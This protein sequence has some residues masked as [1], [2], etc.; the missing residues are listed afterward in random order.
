MPV[1][2]I[3]N[4][5]GDWYFGLVNLVPKAPAS[6][7]N[8]SCADLTESHLLEDFNGTSY[9]I[10]MYVGGCYYYNTTTD[11]WEGIGITVY[12]QMI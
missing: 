9:M 1:D 10:G 7:E 3:Q 12:I 8:G 2:L 5:S 4:R 6:V 11:T